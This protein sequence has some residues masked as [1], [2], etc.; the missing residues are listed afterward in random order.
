VS[1]AAESLGTLLGGR[2]IYAQRRAGYRT[3]I[4][5]QLGPVLASNQVVVYELAQEG[6]NLEALFLQL[7]DSLGGAMPQVAPLPAVPGT[8]S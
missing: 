7:T 8:I 4:E 3:G 2:V 6:M 1:A 5:E